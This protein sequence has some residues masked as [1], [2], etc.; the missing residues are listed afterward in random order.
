MKEKTVYHHTKH[1][2]NTLKDMITTHTNDYT[3]AAEAVSVREGEDNTHTQKSTNTNTNTK[4]RKRR[5]QSYDR[6]CVWVS[7]T[8]VCTASERKSKTKKLMVVS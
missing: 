7:V 2:D 6:K 8:R 1:T 5:K 4:T 3:H